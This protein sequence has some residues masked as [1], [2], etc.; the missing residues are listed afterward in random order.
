MLYTR[1]CRSVHLKSRAA[2]VPWVTGLSAE[3][4]K[5]QWK[6]GLLVFR[7]LVQLY[8]AGIFNQR[9]ARIFKTC[10]AWLLV[11]GTD[12]F[13]LRLSN[14]KMPTAN[15]TIALWC[16]RIK[17]LP[18]RSPKNVIY[19]S[20]CYRILAISSCAMRWKRLKTAGTMN[21]EWTL[22]IGCV[23]NL[24]LWHPSYY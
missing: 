19:F 14:K 13:S 15:T 5:W 1:E 2:S 11:R 9:A 18:V 16:V 12:L 22:K 17:V 4:Y 7:A 23:K 21:Q 20:V 24:I 6:W 10:R 3:N 8:N